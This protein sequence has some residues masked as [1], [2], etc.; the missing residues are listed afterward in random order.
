MQLGFVPRMRIRYT[1]EAE[2]GQ[3]YVPMVN[4][5]LLILVVGVVLAFKKSDNL[6]AAYG[7][8]VTTTM[9]ITTVLA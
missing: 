2:I 4:W 1:S 8:A 9:V 5:M 3:I 6:A 7:I